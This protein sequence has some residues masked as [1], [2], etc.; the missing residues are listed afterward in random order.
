MKF[1][2]LTLIA[3]LLSGCLG[4][5][6]VTGRSQVVFMSADEENAVGAK[7]YHEFLQT[8]KISTNKAQTERIQRIGNKIAKAAKRPDFN[9]EFN[10]VEDKQVNAWCMPGGK[11]VVYTGIL[12]MAKN[13]DQLATV[14][15]HEVSHALARHG[16]E[17]MS[18]QKISSGVQ[19]AANLLLGVTAPEYTN[20]F[21]LAYGVGTKYG[22][23]LPYGRSH[24][25]EADE[26]GIHLMHKAGYNIHE[27]PKFWQNMKAANPNAPME[28]L[29]THPSDDNRIQKISQIITSIEKK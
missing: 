19:Q 22:V 6:P 24:E 17:R 11:V 10:L 8:A 23:M 27:A 21:N 5:T 15:A 18:H 12:A 1:L 9:W 29:S 16:A 2:Y 28:F 13:D 26:I 3:L 4:K 20:A 25:H 7:G 14:M